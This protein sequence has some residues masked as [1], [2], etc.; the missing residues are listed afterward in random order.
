[1]TAAPKLSLYAAGDEFLAQV[2]QLLHDTDLR[3]NIGAR[4]RA[5]V[6]AHFDIEEVAARYLELYNFP[7][8]GAP[9]NRKS[10]NTSQSVPSRARDDYAPW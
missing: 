1:M 8:G 6:A 7:A 5:F 9:G 10:V 2:T 3:Q 4:G